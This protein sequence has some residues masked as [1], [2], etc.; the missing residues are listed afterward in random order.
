MAILHD[1]LRSI[2][3]S[4]PPNP[5]GQRRATWLVFAILAIAM[6]FASSRT[7]DIL[8]CL[9]HLFGLRVSERRFYRFMG[10]PK[11]PWERM[12]KAVWRLVPSPR[13]GRHLILALDDF[14]NPKSGELVYGC[15]H[16]FDHAAKRNQCRYPWSQNIVSLGLLKRVKNRW[17]CLPLA[18]RFYH[19]KKDLEARP[20]QIGKSLVAFE[21]K[22]QQ[23]VDMI[24]QVGAAFAK[25]NLLVVCDSWFGNYGLWKP[26]RGNLGDRCHLLTRLRCNIAIFATPPPPTGKRGRP[27]KYGKRLGNASTLALAYRDQAQISSVYLYGRFR[28]ILAFD[29]VVV[30]R[31][32]RCTVRIVWVFRKSTWVAL[33][34]TD[35]A[36]SVE[37]IIEIYGARWKIEAG[38]KE[39]KQEIGSSHT[40]TRNPNSVGN[41][42]QL[43]M[44]TILLIWIFTDRLDFVPCRRH[45]VRG[46][47]HF[48]FSD[49]RRAFAQAAINT[50]FSWLLPD[51]GKR[52]GISIVA[53][54]LRLVA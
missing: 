7:S 44:L 9:E 19:L 18:A 40:Q 10:S 23:A 43:C 34:S 54:L 42:L 38:F 22:L 15:H 13:T 45:A 11:L 20:I 48:A 16:F 41:H 30:L 12:W 27:R 3:T 36:L 1:V 5:S 51:L 28:K 37:E 25:E 14:I 24:A 50:D 32:L 46:R 31:T 21:T 26:L 2:S 33:C 6:P 47:Q 8:R 35:L 39:L 17:A 52:K 49:A 4:F 53:R 29:Q